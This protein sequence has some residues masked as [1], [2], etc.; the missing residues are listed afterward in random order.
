MFCEFQP[1]YPEYQPR[2]DCWAYEG[3]GGLSTNTYLT[4]F[5]F[6]FQLR[7]ENGNPFMV[8]NIRYDVEVTWHGP[9]MFGVD[10]DIWERQ[11]PNGQNYGQINVFPEAGSGT[12]D[13]GVYGRTNAQG[14][15]R[16]V[17]RLGGPKEA[18]NDPNWPID[19]GWEWPELGGMVIDTGVELKVTIWRP[20][21]QHIVQ[22]F[23]AHF[24]RAQYQ[25]F[26]E[27]APGI[28]GNS[29]QGIGRFPDPFEMEMMS[30][31]NT[32]SDVPL[33]D[34]ILLMSPSLFTS[35]EAKTPKDRAVRYAF[36]ET[37]ETFPKKKVSIKGMVR[38]LSNGITIDQIDFTQLGWACIDP[39]HGHGC[40]WYYF[41]VEEGE[42]LPALFCDLNDPND[43]LGLLNY[44]QP[45]CWWTYLTLPE[46]FDGNSGKC[47][48][49]LRAVDNFNN[50]H[51]VI[52]IISYL[53]DKQANQVL[54]QSEWWV[55][56]ADPNFHGCYED[57]WGN[58][59][60]ALY[61]PEGTHPVLHLPDVF[62]DFNADDKVDF[63]DF[64]LLSNHWQDTIEDPNTKYDALYEEPNN[65]D[66]QI[67]MP[68]VGAFAENWLWQEAG[69]MM[70]Q[71]MSQSLGLTEELY[72]AESVKQPPPQV[73][74]PDIE[75]LIK[76]VEELWRT[77]EEVRKTISEDEWQ[78]FVEALKEEM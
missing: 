53:Y 13:G 57:E 5:G 43:I 11:A 64:A 15:G 9:V 21:G 42:K 55:P 44:C 27:T 59:I 32:T 69:A 12:F 17:S 40:D 29:S 56:S 58:P 60:I 70:G 77:D 10:A 62:G 73:N 20:G 3:D 23:W 38:T 28:Y 35:D 67:S 61:M 33:I 2:P 71:D 68:E 76:W 66:G 36:E 19:T 48:A 52:P 7:D 49:F 51:S 34:E 37:G 75:E 50:V 30:A 24:L 1:D 8:P 74:P 54:L 18:I 14:M 47:S 16:I 45:Y 41:Y 65:W 78:K 39:P 25:G 72:P 26:W 4:G 31:N 63:Y 46:P 6:I 22:Y